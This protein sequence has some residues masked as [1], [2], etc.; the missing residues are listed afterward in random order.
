CVTGKPVTQGGIRGRVEATGRGVYYGLREA[1]GDVDDMK[2][3]GLERGLEGKRVVV[4]GLGNV[5]YHTACFCQEAGCVIIALAE[6]DGA[7]H[8]PEGLDVEAAVKHEKATG[9]LF[10]DEE[11]RRIAR[12]PSEIDLVNSGLEETMIDA[13]QQIRELARRDSRITDL[14]TAAFLSALNKVA[15]SYLELGIFP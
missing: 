6:R 10:S 5:G 3:L 14:R 4:Q 9:R 2:R 11:R 1:C 13:Y 8:R 7:I 15:T 12:G